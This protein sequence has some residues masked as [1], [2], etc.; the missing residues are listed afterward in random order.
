MKTKIVILSS[1]WELSVK[2]ADLFMES[3]LKAIKIKN[4]FSVVLAGGSTPKYLYQFLAEPEISTN[5]KWNKV[6][7]FW[8]DERCVPPDHQ[9]SNYKMVN[10]TLIKR[11]PIPVENVH[12]MKGEMEPSIAATEYQQELITFFMGDRI[13]FDLVILG[14]GVDGHTASLFQDT[15][16]LSSDQWVAA[17]YVSKLDTWRITMT[18]KTINAAH[19]VVFLVAGEAKAKTV[20]YV[21]EEATQAQVLPAQMI[22]PENGSIVW[23][24][25]QAAASILNEG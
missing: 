11:I 20:S 24:L 19:Q 10:D 9:D 16:A 12:R 5:I 15:E 14:L 1:L 4:Q 21:L 25:D 3:A 8:G 17:N 6:H 23:L 13:V 7:I 2:A 18:V 22:S